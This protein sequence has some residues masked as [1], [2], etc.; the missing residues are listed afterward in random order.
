M[1]APNL[2]KACARRTLTP[3]QIHLPRFAQLT[4]GH[5]EDDVEALLLKQ[6]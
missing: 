6:L 3:A 5:V 4:H 2:L 1:S